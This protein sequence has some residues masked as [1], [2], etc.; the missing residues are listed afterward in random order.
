M[1]IIIASKL[2]QKEK[3]EL[4]NLLDIHVLFINVI[5]CVI[6]RSG[7]YNGGIVPLSDSIA[8][9]QEVIRHTK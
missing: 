2:S 5:I 9:E 8:S 6:L 4:S 3:I 7:L 1:I